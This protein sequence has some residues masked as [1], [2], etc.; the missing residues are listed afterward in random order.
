MRHSA[1][2]C[3]CLCLLLSQPQLITNRYALEI[4][5]ETDCCLSDY[6]LSGDLVI[7]DPEPAAPPPPPTMP[8]N[9]QP[10]VSFQQR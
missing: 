7:N 1:Q 4:E 8:A 3:S 9:W 5:A 10:Q 2:L 6:M